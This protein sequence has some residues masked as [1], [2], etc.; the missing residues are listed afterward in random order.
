MVASDPAAAR[1]IVGGATIDIRDAPWQV[2]VWSRSAHGDGDGDGDC[3]GAILSATKILTAA[4]CVVGTEVGADPRRGGLGVWAGVTNMDRPLRTDALQERKVVSARVHPY[5][6]PSGPDEDAS[7][8]GDLA[9]LTLGRPLTLDGVT[10]RAVPLAPMSRAGE[11]PIGLAVAVTGF[12]DKVGGERPKNDGLL[13][14]LESTVVE[15][16]DCFNRENALGLC[17]SH[18]ANTFCDGDSGGPAVA[19]VNGAAAVVGVVSNGPAGCEPGYGATL[20]NITAPEN[21]RF[22]E[23]SRRPPRAPR[24]TDVGDFRGSRTFKV[25]ESLTCTPGSFTGEPRVTVKVTTDDGRTLAQAVNAAVVVPLTADLV[26]RTLTCRAVAANAGGT[27]YSFAHVAAAPVTVD[28][29]LVCDPE[30]S[31]AGWEWW[32]TSRVRRG[33]KIRLEVRLSNA[34]PGAER[35]RIA[36]QK[37]S[38]GRARFNSAERSAIADQRDVSASTW[39]RVPK[40][41]ATGRYEFEISA[42]TDTG[43]DPSTAKVCDDMGVDKTYVRIVR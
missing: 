30:S 35:L 20:V 17:I 27:S 40:N 3:G 1:Q 9:L 12:G 15:P 38:S 26:S 41:V 14:R 22:L 13:R 29:T 5:Y 39:I 11:P 42:R 4:H 24:I 37:F 25:G 33:G 16:D 6:D 2:N 7:T 36:L 28:G 8:A 43:G 10:A 34:S 19:M 21:S 18:P 32:A 23:G 31:Q